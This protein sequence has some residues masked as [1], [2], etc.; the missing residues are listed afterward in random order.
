MMYPTADP[1]STVNL[2]SKALTL[3]FN[4]NEG[5]I[6]KN[7]PFAG[8]RVKSLLFT[9][10]AGQ[11]LKLTTE[12]FGQFRDSVGSEIGAPVFAAEALRCDYNELRVYT[13]AVTRE[14][15]APDF[16]GFSFKNAIT[17]KPDKLSVK[18]E[19]G[20]EDHLRLSGSTYP[21]K[22]RMGR[23]KVAFEMTLDWE[24]PASGFSSV[25]EFNS[26]FS[27]AGSANFTLHWDAGAGHA[28]YIDLPSLHRTGGDPNYNV[29]KDPMVTLKY[30]GLYDAAA[31]KYMVGLMLK[32]T[33]TAV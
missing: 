19:N 23:F 24:D 12:M 27:S 9:Q 14:G 17:L 20:M 5:S 11:Q 3:N 29:S 30:E 8:G 21:D 18:I 13:G 26:R 2:G 15:T 16:T 4:V 10:E 22:T 32:N 7:W 28:L 33:A 6:M 31:T 25:A 1:F